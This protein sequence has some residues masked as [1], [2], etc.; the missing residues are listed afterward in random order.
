L[1]CRRRRRIATPVTAVDTGVAYCVE[2]ALR[3]QG[4]YEERRIVEKEMG[5]QALDKLPWA[6]MFAGVIVI[7][8]AAVGGYQVYANHLTFKAYTDSLSSLAVGVGLV[9]VGR[10]ITKAGKHHANSDANM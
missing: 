3:R 7:I 10:G 1:T 2:S 4:G 9:A 6:T 8:V 5:M